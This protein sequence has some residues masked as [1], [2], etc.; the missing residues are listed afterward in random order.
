MILCGRFA[1]EEEGDHPWHPPSTPTKAIRCKK[2]KAN[3]NPFSS[4]GLD[5]FAMVSADLNAKR[6][7]ILA[8]LGPQDSS[9]VRFMYSY[10]IKRWVPLVVKVKES[11]E[12]KPNKDLSKIKSKNQEIPQPK[13]S[14]VE[15]IT[16]SEEREKP[17]KTENRVSGTN[18][19]V[20]FSQG[21]AKN[22]TGVWFKG[23]SL[24][25]EHFTLVLILLCLVLYGKVFAILCTCMWWYMMPS[26]KNL[27]G[28]RRDSMKKRDYTRRV[29]GKRLVDVGADE[30]RKMVVMQ[31]SLQ[32]DHV[33]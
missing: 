28:E 31:K 27:K 22:K 10:P 1:V 33:K 19:G 23:G 13:S 18:P 26:V 2:S 4:I 15:Q 14:E 8:Q 17:K 7:R 30:G 5:K 9:M 3:K 29:S 6:Q 16:N 24:C 25:Y 20:G 11:N 32:K 21:G 12:R